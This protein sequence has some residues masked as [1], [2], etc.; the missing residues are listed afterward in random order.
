M[1]IM[2][3]VFMLSMMQL[4]KHEAI[5]RVL[6]Y[7]F[8]DL[9]EKIQL[10]SLVNLASFASKKLQK[11]EFHLHS[12]LTGPDKLFD[13]LSSKRTFLNHIIFIIILVEEVFTQGNELDI[14]KS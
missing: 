9:G 2:P 7:M 10:L 1:L 11:Q 3:A 6:K 14:G 12:T 4:E 5:S 13:P 8:T